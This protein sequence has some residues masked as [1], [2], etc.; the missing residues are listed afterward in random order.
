[1]DIKVDIRTPLFLDANNNKIF[2][3]LA[4]LFSSANYFIPYNF[5]RYLIS[6]CII[7]N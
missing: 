2:C 6:V 4:P 3:S 7:N 1:M 5:Y